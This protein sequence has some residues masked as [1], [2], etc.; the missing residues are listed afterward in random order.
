MKPKVLV[1]LKHHASWI[2]TKQHGGDRRL[3]VG[4]FSYC[5]DADQQHAPSH[6]MHRLHQLLITS[7]NPISSVFDFLTGERRWDVPRGSAEFRSGRFV[8]VSRST[9]IRPKAPMVSVRVALTRCRQW[10]F[11]SGSSKD[12]C[13]PYR[14]RSSIVAVG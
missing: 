8:E 14:L 7:G 9:L 5:I 4:N 12:F 6:W 13:P 10:T 11:Q 2:I 1:P 3:A